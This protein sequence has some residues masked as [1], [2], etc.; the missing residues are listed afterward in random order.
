MIGNLMENLQHNSSLE[1]GGLEEN[2]EW[3]GSNFLDISSKK[4]VYFRE[5]S[6]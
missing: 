1:K 4:N 6:I 2:K 5:Q 3:M